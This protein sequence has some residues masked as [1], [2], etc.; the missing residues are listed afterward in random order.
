MGL[1]DTEQQTAMHFPAHL[2]DG[3]QDVLCISQLP[4]LIK[5][6]LYVPSI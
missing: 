2:G 3:G 6:P 5:L 1:V 4:Q